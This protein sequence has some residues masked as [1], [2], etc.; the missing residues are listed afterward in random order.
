M[1]IIPSRFFVIIIIVFRP[2]VY[3]III[4]PFGRARGGKTIWRVISE[5]PHGTGR[6]PFSL[7]S[8]GLSRNRADVLVPKEMRAATAAVCLWYRCANLVCVCVCVSLARAVSFP[9]LFFVQSIGARKTF[10]ARWQSASALTG[11]FRALTGEEGGGCPSFL[12]HSYRQGRRCYSRAQWVV[13]APRAHV[14]AVRNRVLN[15]GSARGA[16][17]IAGTLLDP[18]SLSYCLE[19]ELTEK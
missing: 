19:G 1:P 13:A 6:W 12:F 2:C 14:A 9:V 5:R 11:L 3:F 4:L 18:R 17:G 7:L 8:H 15:S 16:A 10:N